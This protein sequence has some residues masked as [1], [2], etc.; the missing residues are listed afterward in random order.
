[1]KHLKRFWRGLLITIVTVLLAVAIWAFLTLAV[2]LV[3]VASPMILILAIHG[4]YKLAT[5][6]DT[7]KSFLDHLEEALDNAEEELDNTD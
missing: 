5:I 1:M 6:K 3:V 4:S 2:V 7:A